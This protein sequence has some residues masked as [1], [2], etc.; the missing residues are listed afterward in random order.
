[1]E[2]DFLK[3][4]LETEQ[5]AKL[6]VQ[7]AGSRADAKIREAAAALQNRLQEERESRLVELDREYAAFAESLKER[8]NTEL[9]EYDAQ[10]EKEPVFP[11]KAFQAIREVL[12]EP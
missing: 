11:D 10:L 12:S 2:S 4:L 8:R 7:E 1:M 9:Q 5:Q 3:K 6:L